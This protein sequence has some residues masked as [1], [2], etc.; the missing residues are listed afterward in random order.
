MEDENS[1][2]LKRTS[3]ALAHSSWKPK[4][5]IWGKGQL[6]DEAWVWLK[7]NSCFYFIRQCKPE[8]ESD[9]L[10]TNSMLA[11]SR[12]TYQNCDEQ[13]IGS[14]LYGLL[15]HG[16]VHRLKT[17]SKIRH[18]IWYTLY[19]ALRCSIYT[20]NLDSNITI[21]FEAKAF[22]REFVWTLDPHL[23]SGLPWHSMSWSS[24]IYLTCKIPNKIVQ[25]QLWN[26]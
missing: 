4:S 5:N 14:R 21:Y 15:R 13:F 7:I 20:Q 19:L 10:Q 6:L 9:I 23:P 25:S 1:W 8:D 18:W 2:M 24:E 16:I 3:W 17:N 26:L 11:C 12:E 22:G